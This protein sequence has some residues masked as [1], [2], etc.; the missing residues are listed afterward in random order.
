MEEEDCEYLQ[1]LKST[2][3]SISY[4]LGGEWSEWGGWIWEGNIDESYGD[5]RVRSRLDALTS[6]IEM[7]LLWCV[8]IDGENI[9]ML[10]KWMH[11]ALIRSVKILMEI[12]QEI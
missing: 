5:S 12:E 11:S 2:A 6:R 10:F 8:T 1:K 3:A 9:W 4:N 7:R